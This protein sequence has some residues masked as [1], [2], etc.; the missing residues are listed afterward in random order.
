MLLTLLGC[1]MLL[2][3]EELMI[4]TRLDVKVCS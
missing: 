1:V 3:E 4:D 2:E